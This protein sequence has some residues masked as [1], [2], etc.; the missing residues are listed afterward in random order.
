MLKTDITKQRKERHN[1][2]AE[3]FTPKSVCNILIYMSRQLKYNRK[4]TFCDTSCG[5]G[6]IICRY[7]ENRISFMSDDIEEFFD[8]VSRTYGYDIVPENVEE[9]KRNIRK[10]LPVFVDDDTVYGPYLEELNKILDRNIICADYLMVPPAIASGFDLIIQNPPYLQG[11]YLDFME[12]AFDD[13]DDYGELVSIQPATWLI[14]LHNKGKN[15]IYRDLKRKFSHLTTKVI[16]ENYNEKFNTGLY[17]PFSIISV[18]KR[19]VEKFFDVEVCGEKFTCESLGDINMIDSTIGAK[20]IINDIVNKCLAYGDTMKN[21]I[22]QNG[23]TETNKDT[24]YLKY[25]KIIGRSFCGDPRTSE[26]WYVNGLLAPPCYYAI[27]DVRPG[28]SDTPHYQLKNG[29]TYKNP[30]F[31][32]VLSDQVY[33]TK[34]ELENF[35]HNVYHCNIF[36]FIAILFNN[37]MANQSRHYVP[38]IVD[39]KYTEEEIYEILDLNSQEIETIGSTVSKFNKDND[40]YKRLQFGYDSF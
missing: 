31:T 22:Y 30:E 20:A 1:K 27:A 17:V 28:I 19:N 35:V 21:H 6:N 38:W 40:W 10:F 26:G 37:N 36:P 5:T 7:L 11:T 4:L 3:D 16:I 13:L 24:H 12:K 23:K 14:N 15:H 32:D 8:L 33:G 25:L 39:K 9:C 18:Y 34:E 29:R 2:T